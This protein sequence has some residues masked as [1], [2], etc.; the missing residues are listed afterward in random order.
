MI[1]TQCGDRTVAR[2][3]AMNLGSMYE[4]RVLPLFPQVPV[5]MRF[6]S[7]FQSTCCCVGRQ[8]GDASWAVPLIFLSLSV[9]LSRPFN[10]CLLFSLTTSQRLHVR[11]HT[12]TYTHPP[13]TN[14]LLLPTP[15]HRRIYPSIKLFIFFSTN[16]Q[17]AFLGKIC[18]MV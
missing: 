17:K 7:A 9:L 3:E 12:S 15:T 5:S 2:I 4:W 11:I 13:P 1:P 14:A 10:T 8:G 18:S 16:E 6:L